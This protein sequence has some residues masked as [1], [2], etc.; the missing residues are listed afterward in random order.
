MASG[1]LALDP[2]GC[3]PPDQGSTLIPGRRQ[4]SGS[5]RSPRR[6]SNECAHHDQCRRYGSP[7]VVPRVTALETAVVPRRNHLI[8]WAKPGGI[9]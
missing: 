3:H 4:R 5:R 7:G 8:I 9:S 6:R 2:S 1:H